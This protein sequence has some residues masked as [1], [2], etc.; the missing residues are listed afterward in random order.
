GKAQGL[1]SVR[2]ERAQPPLARFTNAGFGDETGD[3]ARRGHVEA[4]IGG[5]APLRRD[6]D[7]R[8][9][10]VRQAAPHG[11]HLPLVALLDR[12]HRARTELPVDRGRRKRNIEGHIVVLGGQGLRIRPDL[13]CDVTVAVTR[14]AP[15]IAMSTL[16]C[17]I[18]CPPA[19]S[20]MIA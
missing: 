16:P 10:A 12:N 20:A 5:G 13:V 7:G 17:C 4:W 15:T 8:N 6:L 18:R 14:S 1:G 2:E 9:S 19:L 3:E 11:R